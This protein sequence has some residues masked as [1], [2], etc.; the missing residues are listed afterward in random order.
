M[1]FSM[2]LLCFVQAL[3]VAEGEIQRQQQ[4]FVGFLTGIARDFRLEFIS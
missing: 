1:G 3:I 2:D 4:Y